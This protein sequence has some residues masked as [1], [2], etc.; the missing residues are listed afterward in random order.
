MIEEFATT[1]KRAKSVPVVIRKNIVFLL[2][3]MHKADTQEQ[4]AVFSH[5]LGELG[6]NTSSIRE[7]VSENY[8]KK[9]RTFVG[10]M[11]SAQPNTTK[12]ETTVSTTKKFNHPLIGVLK[13]FG[14]TGSLKADVFKNTSA[15]KLNGARVFQ[16]NYWSMKHDKDLYTKVIYQLWKKIKESENYDCVLSYNGNY[17]KKMVITNAK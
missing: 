15:L 17:I 13:H 2:D 5:F 8:H 10:H 6:D 9:L 7:D 14:I 11:I 3:N 1:T 16:F 12:K 4:E